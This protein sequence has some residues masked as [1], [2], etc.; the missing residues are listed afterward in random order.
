MRVQMYDP[1]WLRSTQIVCIGHGWKNSV[2]TPV[3]TE[4]KAYGP[5]YHFIFYLNFVKVK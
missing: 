1:I 4:V 3:L 5:V 2:W